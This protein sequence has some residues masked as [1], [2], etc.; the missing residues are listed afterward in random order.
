[1]APASWREGEEALFYVTVSSGKLYEL[2]FRSPADR[3]QETLKLRDQLLAGFLP[4]PGSTDPLGRHRGDI[5]HR[6][7]ELADEAERSRARGRR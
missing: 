5:L 6:F 1:M 2:R 3:V 4:L 7:D